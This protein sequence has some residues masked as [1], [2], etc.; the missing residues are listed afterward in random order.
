MPAEPQ[1]KHSKAAPKEDIEGKGVP[2]RTDEEVGGAVFLQE[3]VQMVPELGHPVQ[4]AQQLLLVGVDVC[5]RLQQLP[6]QVAHQ[7][8]VGW[9]H[10]VG[11]GQHPGGDVGAQGWGCLCTMVPPQHPPWSP[12][13]HM[14]QAQG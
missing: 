13:P 3:G 12:D 6:P 4:H 14:A 2:G 9:L 7:E 1:G 8:A 10:V 11:E 5:V